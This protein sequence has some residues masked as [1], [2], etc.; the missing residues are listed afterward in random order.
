MRVVLDDPSR[1]VI[2]CL[3][4]TL[5]TQGHNV[6]SFTDGIEALEYIKLNNLV[7]SQLHNQAIHIHSKDDFHVFRL[8]LE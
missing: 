1:T 7:S 3:T 4:R 2:K 8:V 5:V 6:H